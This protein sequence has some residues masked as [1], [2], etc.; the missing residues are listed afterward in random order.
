[1]PYES[2]LIDEKTKN[3]MTFAKIKLVSVETSVLFI[4]FKEHL[5]SGK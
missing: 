4:L 1:M 3:Q 2:L 5:S